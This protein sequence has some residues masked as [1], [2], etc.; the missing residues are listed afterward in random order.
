MCDS[1][2][3]ARTRPLMGNV[4]CS[5]LWVGFV[6]ACPAAT[7]LASGTNGDA[8]VVVVAE[9]Q[10]TSRVVVEMAQYQRDKGRLRVTVEDDYADLRRFV[11][12][13][14]QIVVRADYPVRSPAA[15]GS[16]ASNESNS[17]P[18]RCLSVR[19]SWR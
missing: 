10:W 7:V 9:S 4:I 11:S 2:I 6:T 13:R 8:D 12:G 14:C 1:S 15:S 5:L 18:R 19:R 17:S 16:T 3:A